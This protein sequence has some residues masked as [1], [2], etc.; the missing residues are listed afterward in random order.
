MAVVFAGLAGLSLLVSACGGS[1]AGQVA[2]LSSTASST[3]KSSTGPSTTGK[4]AASLAYS[5]CMRSHGVSNFPD[6]KQVGGGIQVSGSAPGIDPKSPLFVS[7]Q[8]SCR[9]LLPGGG[10]PTHARQQQAL[11]RMLRISQCM[12]AHGISGFPDPTL[13]PPSN[14]AGYSEIT[15][16]GVA[17]LAVPDSIDVRSPAFKLAAAACKL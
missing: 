16:N 17:W 3:R 10:R 15:S 1:P 4:Y 9:H 5:R 2:Q 7:A 6:P 11:A 14:R 13:A 8:Q 12:R